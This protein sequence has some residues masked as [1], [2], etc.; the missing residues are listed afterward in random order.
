MS[1]IFDNGNIRPNKLQG[2]KD[3]DYHKKYAK[4]CLSVM[5]NYIYRRYINKCLINWSFFKGQDGQWIFDEDI[6]AFFLDESGDV[7][8]RLK[9]TK[10]VIKPMVQQYVGNAIRLSYNAKA[11]CVSDFV[12][13]QREQELKKIKTMHQLADAIPFFGDTIKEQFNLEEDPVETEELFINTFVDNY[14]TDIN[15]L[16]EYVANDVNMSELKTQITRNLAL[17]GLGIYKGFESGELYMAESVNPLFF[18]WDM[19]AKKPDLTDAE[20]MGEWYYMDSPSIFEKYQNL[21]KEQREAIENYSNKSSQNSMHKIVNEVYTIP[22]GKVPVYEVYW[23][24]VEKREYGWVKDEHDYPYYTM[25]NDEDSKYTDKDLIEPQTEKHKNEMGKKKKHTI[26]V[27][28]LRYCIMIPKEEIGFEDIVL[29]H[30]IV[31]YQEKELGNPANVKFPYKCYTWVYD[32]GEV[33]TPLD[34]VIDPQRFLNRTL[35][36]VESHMANMRGTGTVVSKSAVDDRDGEADIVRNINSSKPIFVDT[37]RV[38]SVGNAIG[39]YGTNI[40]GGTLQMFQV[41]QSVQQSIQDV[42]GVNEAMTGTQGGSDMLVGVIEAQIQRGSLVQEPFYWALTSILKQAFQHMATVGKAIYHDNPRRLAMIVGDE[43]MKRI[44]I[45]ED[46]LLQDYRIFIDR[47][48]TPEQG[49]NAANQLLFTLLQA[50]LID[51][52]VF[53]NLF[54]RATPELVAKEL[55]NFNADK[56]M[57]QMKADQASTQGMVQGKMQQEQAMDQMA[58]AQQQQQLQ[59]AAVQDATHEQEMEKIAM[60]EDAKTERD[61]IKNELKQ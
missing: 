18:V 6:E 61:I 53:A 32:R 2:K 49:R 45:T 46:H 51:N 23:K 59:A 21:S 26:Y 16:L 57:A 25:I 7:R 17:C 60:K 40:G 28:V 54:N 39:T 9:W 56:L 38:G 14:E 19:S 42:T 58:A 8:N 47:A 11:N 30:G 4:Y 55:R 1:F 13:N 15:N 44:N 27:D 50:G 5:N 3:K 37:D 34:D 24:D 48:E 12:I 22:G 10:N 52:N 29:E 33:L 20:Y 36:V 41:I 43:G 35:S 31:P